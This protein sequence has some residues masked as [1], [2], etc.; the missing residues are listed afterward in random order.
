MTALAWHLFVHVAGTLSLPQRA[1]QGACL[2]QPQT[3][4]GYM[5]RA[6]SRASGEELEWGRES[7]REEVGLFRAWQT[8]D[9]QCKHPDWEETKHESGRVQKLDRAG[10]FE[11]VEDLR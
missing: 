2:S 8:S 6:T 11:D 9:V 7:E 5:L 3:H 1:S 10:R 4:D